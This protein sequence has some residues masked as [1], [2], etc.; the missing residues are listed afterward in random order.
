MTPPEDPRVAIVRRWLGEDNPYERADK[1]L[2]ELD[3]VRCAQ[4]LDAEPTEEAPPI[5][6]TPAQ[7]DLLRHALGVQLRGSTYSV[8]YR[9]HYVAGG[10]VT[11]WE[12]LC[13]AGLA[14][15]TNSG[16]VLSGV[17]PIYIVTKAG[18]EVALRGIKVRRRK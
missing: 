3:A 18:R 7:L 11:E 17:D 12:S 14:R 15:K 6:V 2:A 16:N 4:S 9:N 5:E 10:D 8:P 13:A 1:L